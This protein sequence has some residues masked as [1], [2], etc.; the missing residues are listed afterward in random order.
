MTT[1]RDSFTP[2]L[3]PKD[4]QGDEGQ[5]DQGQGDRD[6]VDGADQ[7]QLEEV[8][9]RWR[10]PFQDDSVRR[11]ASSEGAIQQA[12]FDNEVSSASVRQAKTVPNRDT[13]YADY[14]RR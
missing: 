11:T 1:D 2:T 14:F 10:D 5:G 3:A 4:P 9:D 7:E 13:D 12:T 6:S 8:F